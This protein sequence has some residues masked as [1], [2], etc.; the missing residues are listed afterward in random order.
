MSK[1]LYVCPKC[2]AETRVK[3]SAPVPACCGVEMKAPPLPFCETAPNPEMA[4]SDR[5][6]PPCDDATGT[7]KT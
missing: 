3:A 6:D 2:G 1:V 7:K 5:E 4:R